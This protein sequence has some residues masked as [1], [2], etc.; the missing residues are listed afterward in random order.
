MLDDTYG[1]IAHQEQ[2]TPIAQSLSGYSLVEADELRKAMAKKNKSEMLAHT[3]RFIDAPSQTAF[4]MLARFADYARC[5][6]RNASVHD[7]VFKMQLYVGIL[8]R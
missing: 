1:I 8:C 6:L 4:E 2:V 3:K 5:G 7:R